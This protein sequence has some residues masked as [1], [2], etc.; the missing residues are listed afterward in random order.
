MQ[1]LEQ[2]RVKLSY[3]DSLMVFRYLDS[4]G[5]G[6]ICFREFCSLCEEKWRNADPY[7]TM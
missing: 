3:E 7:E 5:N 4:N 1:G 2:L 6:Y